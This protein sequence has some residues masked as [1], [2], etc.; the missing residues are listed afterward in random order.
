M[1]GLAACKST[2]LPA[3]PAIQTETQAQA[4]QRRFDELAKAAFREN[5]AKTETAQ[6][7]R[8]EL[9]FQRAT[10]SCSSWASG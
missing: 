10:Q 4:P 5:H 1:A 7:L 6:T 9:L 8:D 2:P 3:R